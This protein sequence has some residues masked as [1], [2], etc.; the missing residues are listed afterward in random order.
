MKKLYLAII[1]AVIATGMAFNACEKTEISNT[2]NTEL[3][4]F[5]ARKGGNGRG[6]G[7]NQG[8]G[9][10]DTAANQAYLDSLWQVCGMRWSDTGQYYPTVILNNLQTRHQTSYSYD[11]STGGYTYPYDILVITFDAPS[12]PNRTV[13]CYMLFA[14]QCQTRI[15]CNKMNGLYMSQVTTCNNTTTFFLP[16]GT[17]WLNPYTTS[18]TGYIYIGTAE[19]CIY[20]SQPFTFEPPR[21]LQL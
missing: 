9:G 16:I 12:I 13:N 21:I 10:Y 17:T 19:G 6:N 20:M 15:V 5:E 3:P 14:D 7:N 8:G 2:T 1:V 11:Q 18:Y 4:K